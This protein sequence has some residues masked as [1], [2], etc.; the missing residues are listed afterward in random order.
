VNDKRPVYLD[1]GSID[2]PLTATASILHRISG[3]FL[4]AG[5]AVLLW[6]LSDSLAS[7]ESFNGIKAMLDSVLIKLLVWA[8][9]AG[10]IYHSAAGVKHLIMDMGIGETLEGGLAGAKIVFAVSIILTII[11]GALIW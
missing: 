5:T 11:V 4:V 1:L 7:E 8:V 10:L 2:M 6:L 3:I 9:L